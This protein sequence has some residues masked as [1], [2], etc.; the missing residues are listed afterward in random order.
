MPSDTSLGI[1]FWI[2]E[3]PNVL[4][5]FSKGEILLYIFIIFCFKILFIFL[6]FI[7]LR[8]RVSEIEREGVRRETEGEGETGSPLSREPNVGL[9][10]G[11][12][13]L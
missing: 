11:T 1:R 2:A 8:D 7:Y 3:L 4:F 6:T 9:D 12:L 10:P 5:L 13:G